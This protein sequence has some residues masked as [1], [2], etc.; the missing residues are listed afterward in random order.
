MKNKR[1]HT[2]KLAKAIIKSTSGTKFT[3]LFW[4]NS[5]NALLYKKIP[6][7]YFRREAIQGGLDNGCDIKAIKKYI[8]NAKSILEVGAGYGRVLNHIIKNGFKGK[9]FALE[10]EPK[11][12][13]FL[14]KQFPQVQ[15]ICADIR[16]FITKQKFDLILLMWANLCDFSQTE[17][18]PT[19]KNISSHLNTMGFL[20]FDLTP[21]N[22]KIINATNDD[23]YNKTMQTPYGENYGYFPSL[24]EIDQYIQKLN[25][26]KKEIITYT[27]KTNKKRNLYILQKD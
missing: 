2:P 23:Q 5:D 15:I 21:V 19:L 7:N 18:L 20:I 3:K 13:R 9:L 26:F 25:L 1:R 14:E 10:R 11:L 8:K 17:Q 12:C 24:N 22:C 6:L 27:T 16:R 4:N